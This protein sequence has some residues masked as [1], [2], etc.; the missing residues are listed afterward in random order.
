MIDND[1]TINP[2]LFRS[3]FVKDFKK[4]KEDINDYLM[5]DDD[6]KTFYQEL[7][8]IL[9]NIN[10]LIL[11]TNTYNSEENLGISPDQI[12]TQFEGERKIQE[13]MMQLIKKPTF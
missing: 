10:N 12:I 6:N 3:Q 11:K 9:I 13:K 7:K 2:E 8:K 1:T 5:L 4:I